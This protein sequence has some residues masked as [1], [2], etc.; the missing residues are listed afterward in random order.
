MKFI[1]FNDRTVDSALYIQLQGIAHILTNHQDFTFE[2]AYGH[3]IDP[4]KTVITAS[5]FWDLYEE[6]KREAGYKSDVV[7]RALG[8]YH[9]TDIEE[10]L[11]FQK[12]VRKNS[13]KKFTVALFTM[14]ED[15][16]L[17]EL[18]KKEKPGANKWFKQRREML[19]AYFQTQLNTNLMRQFELDTLFCMIAITLLSD[20]PVYSYPVPS[21][22]KLD[23]LIERIRPLLYDVFE[24]NKTSDLT[25]ITKRIFKT[26]EDAIE[27][28]IITAYFVFPIQDIVDW[29]EYK[30]NTSFDDLKRKDALQNDD[31]EDL[32]DKDEQDI[33]DETFSTW[34]GENKNE[35][36]K[37]TF[38]RFELEQGTKTS[39]VGKGAREGSEQD[40]VNATVQGSS[41]KSNQ[42][43][44]ENM[45]ALEKEQ[46]KQEEKKIKYEY[47]E[48]NQH[49]KHL[50][51]LPTSIT[52]EEKVQYVQNQ[53]DVETEIKKLRKTLEKRIE[54][55]RNQQRSDLL[56]G[57]MSKKWIPLITE[58]IPRIFYKKQQPSSELDAVFTLLIDCSASMIDKMENTKKAVVLF[59]EVLKQ[60]RISHSVVG[61]WE[62]AEAAKK[63][64]H[65]NYYHE[66]ISF[67]KSL[68]STEGPSIMQLEPQEDNRDGF[69]I[70]IATEQLEK[71]RE[72]HKFLLVFS[73]GEPS[74]NQYEKFGIIDTFE[75]VKNSRK[76]GIQVVGM[77]LANGEIEES[78]RE[79]MKNIYEKD[80]LMIPNME[81]L[82]Y[83]F[84]SFLKKLLL[85][86]V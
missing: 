57:R 32:D 70:R 86:M 60:L 4:S 76:K 79:V 36:K 75:A 25:A 37:Q 50:I 20:Q 40:Q 69:S 8:T 12:W 22:G 85:R 59:H 71:R 66:V 43:R 6:K 10:C 49:A 7:L 47:G 31:K 77:Y 3:Q 29:D 38:L 55:K 81:D 9:H 64:Y 62:D 1:K 74:A 24:A 33:M 2:L 23:L 35:D 67:E 18:C 41:Q 21:G 39:L 42:Q 48:R 65:P 52:S 73:D 13:H 11:S 58:P 14:L 63:D 34:H 28:D 61:F 54:Q 17:E 16:R 56:Y 27:D 84:S 19:L 5:H 26:I 82:P 78:E 44:Y 46:T 83:I 30:K 15:I 53:K 68:L 45:E 72:K 80:H 51:K